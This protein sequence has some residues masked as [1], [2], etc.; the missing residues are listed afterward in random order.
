M[1]ISTV[2]KHCNSNIDQLSPNIFLAPLLL[3]HVH[4]LP[5]FHATSTKPF[6]CAQSNTCV[7]RIWFCT[8][9][10]AND[11]YFGSHI[12]DVTNSSHST[13][14]LWWPSESSTLALLLVSCTVMMGTDR[15]CK[16]TILFPA[17]CMDFTKSSIRVF[18]KRTGEINMLTTLKLTLV[19]DS[20]VQ[21]WSRILPEIYKLLSNTLPISG[22]LCWCVYLS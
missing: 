7:P 19:R 22:M 20:P 17:Y 15:N 11:I 9:C 21:N 14:T 3:M 4:V 18:F 10:R 8:T 6:A 5:R 16:K 12:M 2:V 1:F 13:L